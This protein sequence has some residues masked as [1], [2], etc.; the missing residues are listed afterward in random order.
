MKIGGLGGGIIM[1]TK[2]KTYGARFKVK[3]ALNVY[4][5]NTKENLLD[6]LLGTRKYSRNVIE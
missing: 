5:G 1:S 6:F 3:V 2:R 4:K